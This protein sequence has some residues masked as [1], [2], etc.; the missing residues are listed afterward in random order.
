MIQKWPCVLV[1]RTKD[2]GAYEKDWC[3][4]TAGSIPNNTQQ[5]YFDY[6]TFAR[7]KTF[8]GSI[9]LASFF[10]TDKCIRENKLSADS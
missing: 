4:L 2:G 10:A 1:W 6:L 7:V 9:E 3:A 5:G 8:P